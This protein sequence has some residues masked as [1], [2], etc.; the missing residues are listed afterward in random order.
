MRITITDDQGFVTDTFEVETVDAISLA[1]TVEDGLGEDYWNCDS[2]DHW[3]H[4]S[5]D[6][7]EPVDGDIVLLC[8]GCAA[9]ESHV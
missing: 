9:R 6:A 4:N 7:H 8:P 1:S 5:V 2:C 3:F